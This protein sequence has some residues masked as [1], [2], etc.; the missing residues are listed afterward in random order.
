VLGF[1]TASILEVDRAAFPH[2]MRWLNDGRSGQTAVYSLI[3]ALDNIPPEEFDLE[4]L[5]TLVRVAFP[6]YPV[7]SWEN[8]ALR[9]LLRTPRNRTLLFHQ[10][11]KAEGL[12]PGSASPR[13]P[14]RFAGDEHV[15]R[16]AKVWEHFGA[17]SSAAMYQSILLRMSTD[18]PLLRLKSR[19]ITR[20]HNWFLQTQH[21]DELA[22]HRLLA[23]ELVYVWRKLSQDLRRLPNRRWDSRVMAMSNFVGDIQQRLIHP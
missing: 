12:L 2:L 7:G 23:E 5:R 13:N 22:A 6:Q 3:I 14:L 4:I 11:M 16:A 17:A 20:W 18:E 21:G 1:F 19:R 8:D 15:L 9:I 10:V